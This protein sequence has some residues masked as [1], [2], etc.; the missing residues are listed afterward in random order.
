MGG[1]TNRG[2]DFSTLLLVWSTLEK[3]TD[4]KCVEQ[5]CA[6]TSTVQYSI[7]K[8]SVNTVLYVIVLYFTVLYITVLCITVLYIAVLCITVLYITVLSITVLYSTVM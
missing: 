7:V 6:L 2:W 3:D 5:H 4:M 1:N 8:L